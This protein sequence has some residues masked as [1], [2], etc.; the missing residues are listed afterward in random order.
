MK[1]DLKNKPLLN[2]V[3]VLVFNFLVIKILGLTP[4]PEKVFPFINRFFSKL[5]FRFSSIFTFS[6]G[7]I[8]Y[9]LLL[10]IALIFVIKIIINLL[11]RDFKKFRKQLSVLIYTVSVFYF[12]MY[13]FWGFN[14]YKKPIVSYYNSELDTI[15]ELKDLA[16]YYYLEA[17]KYRAE[18]KEN[19]RGV[20]VSKISDTE[21][22]EELIN[23]KNKLE[24][25][26]ELNFSGYSEPNLK[27]SLFSKITAHLGISGYYNPFTNESQYNSIN[28]DTRKIVAMLH[29]T[30]HQYGFASE[31]EANFVGFLLGINSENPDLLYASNFRAMR[32][33]LN[34]IL[35]YDPEYVKDF[36]EN[37]Y[38]YGMKMDREY[39]IEIDEN[40]SGHSEDIFAMMNDAFLKLNNQEGLQSYG[41][42]V[43][44]LVGYNREYSVKK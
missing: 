31:S 13:L 6:I 14:Y 43:E 28:P 36:I 2:S 3:L 9:L 38:T 1:L 30:A 17:V 20:F 22:R 7:D 32:S 37:K 39:E 27:K 34:R 10:L 12:I 35:W 16:E 5:L 18:I 4:F 25:Y 42:F 15:D 19:E 24:K 8:F 33:L 21:L 11:K 40:Y 26:A 41:R 23:S 44:L 29:E